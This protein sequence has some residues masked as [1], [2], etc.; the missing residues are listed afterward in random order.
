V[1]STLSGPPSELAV[2]DAYLR[3][4]H[5]FEG[6]Q[7]AR[8][9]LYGDYTPFFDT[10][11]LVLDFGCGDGTWLDVLR[12]AGLRGVGIDY[13]PGKVADCHA[14]GLD[15]ICSDDLLD[16]AD[17][18]PTALT[19][20][21]IIEHLE[22]KA[23]LRLLMTLDVRKVVIV[24]PN[25]DHPI[26]PQTFWRDITHVRPYPRLVIEQ[27]CRACGFTGVMSG[28]QNND[29]DTFVFAYKPGTPGWPEPEPEPEPA[30]EA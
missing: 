24:T 23:V 10:G 30:P 19:A 25:I 27:L 9:T 4:S 26:V 21:H 16:A 28:T 29:L 8:A 17:R 15:A 14:K 1:T 3:V 6:A 5:A 20:L 2:H 7:D 18:E 13:D 22:P 11:D 12:G